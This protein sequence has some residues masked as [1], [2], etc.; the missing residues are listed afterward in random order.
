MGDCLAAPRSIGFADRAAA[1]LV[2]S[3]VTIDYRGSRQ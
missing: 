3:G 2:P 1:R